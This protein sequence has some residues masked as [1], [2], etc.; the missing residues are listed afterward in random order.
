MTDSTPR[1][2]P[3]H[4]ADVLYASL[5]DLAR[6]E[7]WPSVTPF[8]ECCDD[9]AGGAV[10]YVLQTHEVEAAPE[11]KRQRDLLLEA[12]RRAIGML[13]TTRGWLKD[14]DAPEHD[15]DLQDAIDNYRAILARIDGE[16]TDD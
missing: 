12:L 1:G 7:D 9:L 14:A 16:K 10:V 5:D 6:Q 15:D 4:T 8:E 2:K 3:A 13:Q 11:T